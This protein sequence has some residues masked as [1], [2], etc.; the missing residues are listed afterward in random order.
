MPIKTKYIK[1]VTIIW[2][3]YKGW[4]GTVKNKI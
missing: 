3:K 1:C 4:Y 2:Y